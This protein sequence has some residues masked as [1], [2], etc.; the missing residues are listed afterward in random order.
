MKRACFLII[1]LICLSPLYASGRCIEGDCMN[2]WGTKTFPD[3]KRYEGAWKDGAPHGR[4]IL[5]LPGGA[6]YVGK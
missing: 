1:L 6:K 5:T 2:G 3:G 4:G